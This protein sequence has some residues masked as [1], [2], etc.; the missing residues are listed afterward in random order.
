MIQHLMLV[1][2]S[3]FNTFIYFYDIYGPTMKETVSTLI[4]FLQLYDLTVSARRLVID[5]EFLY[6]LRIT[7]VLQLA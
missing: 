3:L 2:G 5:N 4:N 1:A 6:G 7:C